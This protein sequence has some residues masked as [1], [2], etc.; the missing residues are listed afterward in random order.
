MANL[1][2]T[3]TS[4]YSGPTF[5]YDI[6]YSQTGRTSSTV[7]YKVTVSAYM[8]YSTSWFGYALNGYFQ[9]G[10]K[11]VQIIAKGNTTWSG[12]AKHT[13]TK[14]I[15]CDTSSSSGTVNAKFWTTT[16]NS[17]GNSGK[18][19]VSGTFNKT[20]APSTGGSGGGTTPTP[21]PEPSSKGYIFKRVGGVWKD[22]CDIKG[23]TKKTGGSWKDAIILRRTSGKWIQIYPVVTTDGSAGSGGSG[24]TSTGGYVIVKG[25]THRYKNTYHNWDPGV[26]KQGNWGYGNCYGVFGINRNQFKGNGNVTKVTGAYI[27]GYRDASGYYNNNQTIRF[28]RSNNSGSGSS[29]GYTGNFTATTGAPG[30]NKW[31]VGNRTISGLSNVRDFLNGVN[32]YNNLLIYSSANAD[33]LGLQNV[34]LAI[35]YEYKPVV[36]YFDNPE[37]ASYMSEAELKNEAISNPYLTM[38]LYPEEVN[39][40]LD[41]IFKR[42]LLLGIPDLDATTLKPVEPNDPPYSGDYKV[43]NGKFTVEIFNIFDNR[44]AQYSLDETEWKDLHFNVTTG[45]YEGEILGRYN[46][47]FIRVIDTTKDELLY[48]HKYDK[49]KILI[50]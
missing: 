6:S 1:S 24:S 48:Q 35:Q 11:Q 30:A 32:G 33:Y 12:T 47:I 38:L 9:V 42:R 4:P 18:I 20:A 26:A 2:G 22:Y 10:G 23:I 29:I 13:F 21:D 44:T 27:T 19:S 50:N 17:P 45:M 39:M 7:T 8:T 25:G 49:P 46:N 28:Y 31:M 34:S 43:K 3:Y 36:A 5:K 41:E 14:T 37:K 15:T 16:P 40:T